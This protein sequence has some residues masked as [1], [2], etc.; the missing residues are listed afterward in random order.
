MSDLKTTVVG[1]YP[2]PSWLAGA[3]TRE[4]LRDAVLAVLKTQENAGIDIVSDGELARFDVD[5]PD[6]NGMIDYF[7]GPLEGID[8]HPTRADI[9]K[10][11]A[12]E[13]AAYRREPAA[14]LRG[15][16]GEGRLHL[17][18]DWEFVRDLT[19]QPLKFTCTGPHMLAKV[20]MDEHYGDV[21]R[22][23][24]ELAEILARQLASIDAAVVQLDEAN[25]TGHPD[26]TGWAAET[27]NT[28]LR[29]VPREDGRERAVH[30]CFGNYGGQTIQAGDWRR[31]IDYLNALDAD[32]LVLECARRDPEELSAFAGVRPEI[33]L[34]IGVI[35]IKDNRIESASDV[36]AA[37]ERA[38]NAVGGIDRIRYVHPDCG[39]WML[40]RGVADRKMDALVRGRDLFLKR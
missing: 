2:V 14:V 40:P 15:P 21:K 24:A 36:A 12:S 23:A 6:T 31:L 22:V 13:I 1:S 4:A 17:L 33:A 10:F 20:V 34:G 16:L 28:V 18:R 35:D 7:L 26:E 11:R 5:H 39:F 8:L 3:R 25:V 29:S 9:A 30:L 19:R 32:H 37:I 27:L 38:A